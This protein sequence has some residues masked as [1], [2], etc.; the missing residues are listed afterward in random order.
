[1][2]L[3]EERRRMLEVYDYLPELDAEVPEYALDKRNVGSLARDFALPTGR[4]HIAS[5]VRDYG[6]P[7][8][9]R[10]VGALARQ[11]ML[12]SGGK[13]N[14]ASLARYYMLPQ[15]G[16]RNVAALARDAS[17]PYGKRYLGSL[18][19]SGGYPARDYDEGKRS[20]AS[21]ARNSDWPIFAKRG[22]TAAAGRMIVR[23]LN[24]HGR[25]LNND[26]EV[27]SEPLDLQQLIRQGQN[28]DQVKQDVPEWRASPNVSEESLDETKSRNRSN[29]RIDAASQTRHK[30]QIDF[31]DE[32]PLP[33]MQN[34]NML[35]YEDMMETFP[36][37]Y[38]EKRFMGEWFN[39]LRCFM[40][41]HGGG[42]PLFVSTK[43]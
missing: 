32:Y 1:M 26:R 36:D 21:L 28:G 25:S 41:A 4:R 40:F 39:A 33:V 35:E 10:N 18:A 24:R 23:V 2:L 20:I 43:I 5:V 9:K 19:R 38:P 13:R 14:M 22:G 15:A 34:S 7:S 17:L 30:R 42:P 12:P 3:D 31:S 37:H 29:R 6:L 8:G 16:K 27:H 11:S